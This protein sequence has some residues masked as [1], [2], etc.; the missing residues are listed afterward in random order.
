MLKFLIYE[1]DDGDLIIQGFSSL[2]SEKSFD[3]LIAN[4]TIPNSDNFI[5]H[6]LEGCGARHTDHSGNC[7][8]FK[9]TDHVDKWHMENG[10]LVTDTNWEKVL[11]PHS[12]LSRKIRKRALDS[13]EAEHEKEN[14]DTVKL[15][16]LRWEYDKALEWGR[17]ENY[18]IYEAALRIM[19]E[20][21]LEKPLIRKKLQAKI[22]SL[23]SK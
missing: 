21:G 19:D 14:P 4:H 9:A 16:K 1:K 8:D 11:I 22:D 12:E 6:K 18:R 20:E 7:C 3:E 5:L 17:V 13:I 15:S 2:Y 23:K 10:K